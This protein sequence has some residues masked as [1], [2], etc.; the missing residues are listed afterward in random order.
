VLPS[1]I[2]SE[3]TTEAADD[4]TK[5]LATSEQRKQFSLALE[6][7]ATLCSLQRPIGPLTSSQKETLVQIIQETVLDGSLNLDNT[8]TTILSSFSN[9]SDAREMH[10]KAVV[11]GCSSFLMK[12]YQNL[13]GRHQGQE[14]QDHSAK[15]QL[16]S[17]IRTLVS[18]AKSRPLNYSRASDALLPAFKVVSKLLLKPG[19]YMLVQP[20]VEL[21]LVGLAV[22]S[23]TGREH[24]S[25]GSLE[26][27]LR[28]LLLSSD[29][30]VVFL[31]CCE[32]QTFLALYETPPSEED[33][34]QDLFEDT[35]MAVYYRW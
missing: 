24:S 12:C 5:I 18:V 29:E 34:G 35:T 19:S 13:T 16:L 1:V 11:L 9:E 32:I 31:A 17:C 20:F 26:K 28:S 2:S 14:E 25:N 27:S 23:K 3:C 21:C 22:A 4:D 33:G 10:D 15:A 8:M 30:S 6:S 7:F